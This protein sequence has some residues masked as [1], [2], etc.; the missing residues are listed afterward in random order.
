MDFKFYFEKESFLPFSQSSSVSFVVQKLHFAIFVYNLKLPKA[1]NLSNK[2][3][4][5]FIIYPVSLMQLW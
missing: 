5:H 1:H 2:Q 4:T 3:S